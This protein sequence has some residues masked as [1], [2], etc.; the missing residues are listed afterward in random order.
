MLKIDLHGQNRF[1]AKINLTSF[2]VEC[3]LKKIKHASI[4]HGN[5][6]HVL[7]QV[8]VE[9]LKNNK[10]VESYTFAPPWQGGSGITVVTFNYN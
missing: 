2:L 10:F 9:T 1:E 8:V 5:G 7:R 4:C 6:K 3:N